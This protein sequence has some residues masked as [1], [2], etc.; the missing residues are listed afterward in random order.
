VFPFG[1]P[2]RPQPLRLSASPFLN[3]VLDRGRFLVRVYLLPRAV[4]PRAF[5]HPP[6]EG[7]TFDIERT[8]AYALHM[9]SSPY[10]RRP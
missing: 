6:A 8:I 9:L 4:G 10:L 2:P 7:A 1:N 3:V 5:S